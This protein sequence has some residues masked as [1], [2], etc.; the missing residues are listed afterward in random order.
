[1]LKKDEFGRWIS[2]IGRCFVIVC[3][4]L[5]IPVVAFAEDVKKPNVAGAFYPKSAD[6]LRRGSVVLIMPVMSKRTGSRRSIVP[7]RDTFIPAPR[8]IRV[9][10]ASLE[11]L[12]DGVNLARATIFLFTG[13]RFYAQ[14]F[15]TDA[16]GVWISMRRRHQAFFRRQGPGRRRK[17]VIEQEQSMKSSFLSYS[18][19]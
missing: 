12:C 5:V 16:A 7:L 9:Q 1:M 14:G 17:G 2:A 3:W 15:F 10:G 8:R 6:D 11:G 13:S 19:A 18:R 4:S